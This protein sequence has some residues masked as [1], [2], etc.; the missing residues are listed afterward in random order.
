MMRWRIAWLSLLLAGVIHAGPSCAE[1]RD[2]DAAPS[3]YRAEYEV[4]R[5]G[6]LLGRGV[7]TLTATAPDRW[8]LQSVTRGSAGLAGIAGVKI[9]ERSNVQQVDGRL[10]TTGYRYQQNAA[11]RSRERSLSIDARAGRVISRDRDRSYEFDL[12]PGLLDRH[13]VALALATD[14]RAGKRDGLVY[15]VA[16]RDSIDQQRFRVAQQETIDSPAGPL[17]T[18]RV[19]RVRDANA[20]RTTSTWFG[21][22]HGY[23]PVRVL[24]HESDGD[25]M[26]LRLL[27]M[28]RP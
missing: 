20:G 15:R 4:L 19:E 26:E 24:Q 2:G 18:L 16:D 14:L 23:I 25:S 6:K 9:D 27:S 11:W 10:Q 12:E 13:S 8:E 17:R 22:D 3:P 21:I 5:N 1:S 7:V 28:R